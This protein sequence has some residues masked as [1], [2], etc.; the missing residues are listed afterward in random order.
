MER[1]I[2]ISERGTGHKAWC[3]CVVLCVP[4]FNIMGAFCFW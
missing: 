2:K 3:C 4:A 1:K